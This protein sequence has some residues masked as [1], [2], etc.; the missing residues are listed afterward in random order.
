MNNLGSPE[1]P[2]IGFGSILAATNNFSGSNKLGEGGFGPVYKVIGGNKM[3]GKR[4][5]S[6]IGII[7]YIPNCC[8]GCTERR[9][10]SG[11]QEAFVLFRPRFRGI[12]K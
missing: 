1:F 11:D 6:K 3:L 8:T 7:Y 5:I 4:T 2:C 9:E 10:R 12:H